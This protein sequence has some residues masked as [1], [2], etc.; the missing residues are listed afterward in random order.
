MKKTFIVYFLLTTGIFVLAV[1]IAKSDLLLMIDAPS[2]AL[3]LGPTILMLLSHYGPGEIIGA[4]R[5]AMEKSGA[6][7]KELKNALLFFSTA[8]TLMI[9]STVVAVFLGI[10]MILGAVWKGYDNSARV[11]SGWMA[12]DFIAI[13]YL[14]LA[15]LLVTV[16][17]KSA[18]QKKLNAL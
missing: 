6:T 5:A 8:Q 10:I 7:E 15:M 2:L 4:F 1:I 3:V 9:A 11:L 16:P 17:F 12:V 14:A 13:L 18:V